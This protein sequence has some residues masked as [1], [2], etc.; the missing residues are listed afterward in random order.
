MQDVC[1]MNPRLV[2]AMP[3]TPLEGHRFDSC[4]QNSDF[5]SRELVNACMRNGR[6]IEITVF[7][8]LGGWGRSDK[9]SAHAPQI[10]DSSENR[11]RMLHFNR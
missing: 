9:M 11:L 10:C 8:S 1:H 6:V 5:L 2:G 3:L 7:L 4:S